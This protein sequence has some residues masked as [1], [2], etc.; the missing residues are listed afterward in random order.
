MMDEWES[1]LSAV[2]NMIV[3]GALAL[4]VLLALLLPVSR[5]LPIP[6]LIRFAAVAASAVVIVV[7]VVAVVIE[8]QPPAQETLEQRPNAPPSR[9]PAAPRESQEVGQELRAN[10]TV[11]QGQVYRVSDEE[12][13]IQVHRLIMEDDSTIELSED[14]SRLEIR[15]QEVIIHDRVVIMARGADG[16]DGGDGTTPGGSVALCSEG[17]AG[18]LGRDGLNGGNG[19]NVDIVMGVVSIGSLFIDVS[20]GRGGDGGMGGV[21]QGGARGSCQLELGHCGCNGGRGGPGGRGGTAGSGGDG[22]SVSIQYWSFDESTSVAVSQ[23]VEEGE[24]GMAGV[25]GRGG[26]GGAAFGCQNICA[27]FGTTKAAGSTGRSGEAGGEGDTG[28]RGSYMLRA[29]R[30]VTLFWQAERHPRRDSAS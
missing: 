18:G 25:P 7:V 20:G 29:I 23:S 9:E 15:A 17:R 4:L 8:P 19:K 5:R 14:V 21:G 2:D 10:L 16:A 12:A 24:P 13:I 6:G 27:P 26:S 30:Q 3:L 1:I 22:G 28:N 11:Q